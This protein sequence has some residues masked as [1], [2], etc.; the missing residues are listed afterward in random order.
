LGITYEQLGLLTDAE[1]YLTHA[2]ALDPDNFLASHALGR[3]QHI[4]AGQN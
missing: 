2:L 3:V 1:N 4:L